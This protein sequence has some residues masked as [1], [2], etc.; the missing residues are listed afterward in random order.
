MRIV[1]R[2][3]A[4]FDAGNPPG[5]AR[6]AAFT[7]IG[8]R[9]LPNPILFWV[10]RVSRQRT[11]CLMCSAYQWAPPHRLMSWTTGLP[12]LGVYLR[13]T[14]LVCLRPVFPPAWTCTLLRAH[15][16]QPSAASCRR[17]CEGRA[18]KGLWAYHLTTLLWRSSGITAP[19]GDSP[20]SSAHACTGC[21]EGRFA[22]GCFIVCSAA[23]FA[24]NWGRQCS[25]Q[26][27]YH[28]MACATH[29]FATVVVIK[30]R[31]CVPQICYHL[32]FT[33]TTACTESQVVAAA[34]RFHAVG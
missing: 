22:E 14:S 8:C 20:C 7:T 29:N 28:F 16:P 31:W 3:R 6:T 11:R 12:Q 17:F 34:L 30:S 2:T 1:Q 32:H 9:S 33:V 27:L 26:I 19:A 5:L 21:R 13:D 4:T 15:S 10:F 23:H 24:F 18:R 25:V